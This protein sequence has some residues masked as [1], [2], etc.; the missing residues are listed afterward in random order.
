MELVDTVTEQLKDEITVLKEEA[1]HLVNTYHQTLLQSQHLEK[2]SGVRRVIYAR[3][4]N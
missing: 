3:D 2:L 4:E 1:S